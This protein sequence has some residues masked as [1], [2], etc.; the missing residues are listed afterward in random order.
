MNNMVSDVINPDL[1]HSIEGK[2]RELDALRPF[3]TEL[4]RKLEEQFTVEC[5]YNTNAIEG[6]TLTLRE[7]ELVIN[8]GL[9]IGKKSLKEHFEAINH[10]D[11]I[12]YL[13]DFVQKKKELDENAIFALHKII[14]KNIDNIDGGHYRTSNVMI[15]GAIHIPPS[16]IKIQRL[17]NEFFEWYYTYKT[18][19]SIAELAAWVHY[20]LVHIHPF[21]DGNGRTA[22]LL[23]NLVLIQ[24]GYPPAVILN[25]DRKKYYRVLKDAD[26]EKYNDFF[27]FIG[28]SIE[29]SLLIYL[30]AMKSK[31][32]IEDKYG[33]ISLQEATK[34]CDY[35]IEYLSFLARTGKL[36]AVK[37]RRNWMTTREA[38]LEYLEG[39]KSPK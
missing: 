29:R 15:T 25:V 30:N 39:K 14:L 22:R 35:G 21:I 20:K 10:K 18:E 4:V 2:K 24:N 3:S 38:V 17:M 32:D 34:L 23:M 11:G 9:T 12:N 28:R 36:Q 26:R 16:A 7:T 31:N 13:Y 6:N 37:I 27:D 8:R 5:T 19:L 33:Y 1:L